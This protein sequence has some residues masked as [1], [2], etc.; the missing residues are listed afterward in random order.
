MQK[1]RLYG[2]NLGEAAGACYR[3]F[4]ELALPGE[5]NLL[6]NN[7]PD[8]AR[9]ILSEPGEPKRVRVEAHV[10]VRA[11]SSKPNSGSW[12][13]RSVRTGV[14]AGQES[15]YAQVEFKP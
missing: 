2:R 5:G 7:T 15:S 12:P 6:R 4:G 9:R 8:G 3:L 11:L 14:R 1:G 13:N 10:K